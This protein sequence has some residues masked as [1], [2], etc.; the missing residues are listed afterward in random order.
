[1]DSKASGQQPDDL[2]WAGERLTEAVITGAVR[3]FLEEKVDGNWHADKVR[4]A[5]LHEHG[6]DLVM[7][8]GK[9]NS[10]YFKIECKGKSYAKSARSINHEGWLNAL[11]Q[12]ITRIDVERV[13]KSGHINRAYKYGLGLPK[14]GAEVALV[15]IPH[16][17]ARLLNL[18]VFSV[19]DDFYITIYTPKDFR[20]R[21]QG[22]HK[23]SK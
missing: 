8:G 4:Q 14:V 5:R 19:D 3:R 6:P 7:V 17:I 13:D 12:L 21:Q 2:A 10:E 15:R 1:M 9:R 20:K 16:K 22:G 23:H 11:G 18:Y